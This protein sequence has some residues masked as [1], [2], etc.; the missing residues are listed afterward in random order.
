MLDNASTAAGGDRDELDEQLAAQVVEHAR[1]QGT[2]LVGPDGLLGKL[3]K[4]VFETGLEAEMDEHLG[5]QAHEVAGRNSGNSRN[6]TRAKMVTTEL[7][8][9]ELEVPRDRN[10]T[11]EP[12]LVRKRQ[13]RLTGL[14]GLPL[15]AARRRS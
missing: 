8:P 14:P 7:G 2:S 10:S 13:R 11:F 1:A 12:Q 5:Y 15:L 3:T 4:L 6:G 9:L